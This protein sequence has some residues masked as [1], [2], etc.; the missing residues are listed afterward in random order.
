MKTVK[1]TFVFALCSILLMSC[2]GKKDGSSNENASGSEKAAKKSPDQ[3][4]SEKLV[5]VFLEDDE[6]KDGVAIKDRTTEFFKDGK[7]QA[8]FT[9]EEFDEDMGEFISMKY[10][11]MGTWKIEKG[12]LKAVAESLTTDPE[13]PKEDCKSFIDQINKKNTADKIIEITEQ[14]FVY[15][16]A[17]GERKSMKRKVQ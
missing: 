10:N 17:D 8:K 7:F 4:M 11:F 3:E 1:Y 5:G 13:T 15:D 9:R 12:Y 6:E 14:K 2:G 16:N